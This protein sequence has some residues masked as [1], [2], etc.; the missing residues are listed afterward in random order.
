[1]RKMLLIAVLASASAHAEFKDGNKLLSDMTGVTINQMNAIGYVMGVAD[2]L[3]GITHCSPSTVTAG[4]MHDMVKQYLETS[5]SMRHFSADS[6]INRV[7]SNA[8]PCAKKGQA[9]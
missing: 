2:T 5:P 7:L 8:W 6:L 4:Q 9:L 3:A 1:M